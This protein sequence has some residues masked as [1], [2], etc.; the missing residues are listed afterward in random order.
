MPII[1]VAVALRHIAT[2]MIACGKQTRLAAANAREP[3]C[4][5]LRRA[6]VSLFAAIDR[7][8]AEPRFRRLEQRSHTASC[9]FYRRFCELPTSRDGSAR[10][11]REL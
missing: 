4:R 1:V 3:H 7:D 2:S 9:C 11:A 8:C 6:R 5:R 10:L